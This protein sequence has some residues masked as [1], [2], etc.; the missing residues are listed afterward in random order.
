MGV[1]LD[2]AHGAERGAP[3]PGNLQEQ[4]SDIHSNHLAI[5]PDPLGKLKQGLSRAATNV[6]HDVPA[7]WSQL[8]DDAQPKR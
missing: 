5:R 6:Q 3:S 8:L 1:R 7:S 2:Q 4:R